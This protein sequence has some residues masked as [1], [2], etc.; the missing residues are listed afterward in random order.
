[1]HIKHPL[2]IYRVLCTTCSRLNFKKAFLVFFH[3]YTYILAFFSSALLL[4][5]I[6]SFEQELRTARVLWKAFLVFFRLKKLF[7]MSLN[8]H[9][10]NIPFT[11]E[12][13]IARLDCTPRLSTVHLMT[14]TNCESNDP[15]THMAVNFSLPNEMQHTIC[16]LYST[17]L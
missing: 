10:H 12:L 3:T 1:M 16:K 15:L 9:I 5:S 11:P 14:C 17:G 6:F 7:L 2:S 13:Q 4:R 8:I